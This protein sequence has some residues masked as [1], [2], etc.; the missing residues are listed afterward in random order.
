VDDAVNRFF[1]RLVDESPHPLLRTADGT[2]RFDLSDGSDTEHWFVALDAGAVTVTHDEAEA[3]CIVATDRGVFEGVV[4]G[5][6]NFFA[7]MLRGEITASGA[8]G[9]LVRFQRLLPG[10]P[11]GDQAEP[12]TAGTAGT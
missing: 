11:A 10:P 9:L 2:I 3:D 8:L 12:T 4:A 6:M 7:T 5:R 1:D